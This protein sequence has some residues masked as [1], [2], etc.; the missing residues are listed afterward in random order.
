[1]PPKRKPERAEQDAG[2]S[3]KRLKILGR[4]SSGDPV[5][6]AVLSPYYRK[7][8]TLREYLISRLPSS[9]KVRRKKINSV[10]HCKGS[11][12]CDKRVEDASLAQYL[13]STLVGVL[14]KNIKSDEDR[15]KQ[16]YSYSQLAD[17]SEPTVHSGLGDGGWSQSEV[18]IPLVQC[19][20]GTENGCGS[21]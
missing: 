19:S 21:H 20:V 1:M 12:S 13:D 7:V 16:L 8:L 17:I 15:L 3:N 5:R 18:C 11:H 10:G 6:L 4:L 9:S 2:Y 14:E